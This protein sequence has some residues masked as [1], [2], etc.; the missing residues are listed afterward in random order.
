MLPFFPGENN[1]LVFEV[2][3]WLFDDHTMRSD[4]LVQ[5]RLQQR[6]PLT[7]DGGRAILWSCRC[8]Q[9]P[10]YELGRSAWFVRLTEEQL[11]RIALQLG[12]ELQASALLPAL[13]CPLCASIHLGGMPRIEEY[14]NGC[15][16]RLTWEAR[17]S[18][19]ARLC[20]IVYKSNIYSNRDLL[21]EACASSSD[22]LTTPVG[23]MRRMF[24]WLMELPDPQKGEAM[25]LP[26]DIQEAMSRMNPP[27]SGFSWCGYAWRSECPTMGQVLIAQ[28]ITYP[29]SLMCLAE[30]LVACWRQIA[31]VMYEVLA[32]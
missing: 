30:L 28:A 18:P 26:K 17:K 8:C 19:W 14:Y 11:I 32:C 12:L 27:Q 2:V 1:D 29:S 24:T 23:Q 25:L 10:W 6:A 5:R 15:G 13:I 31:G 16:Y 9:K 20:C 21:A 7:L 3:P 22:V 4:F